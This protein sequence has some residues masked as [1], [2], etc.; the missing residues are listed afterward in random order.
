L[1]TIV[2]ERGRFATDERSRAIGRFAGLTLFSS[3][4]PSPSLSPSLS[5]ITITITR[6]SRRRRVVGHGDWSD[7]PREAHEEVGG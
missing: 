6:R 5:P 1:D 2:H 7:G 4:S 3:P